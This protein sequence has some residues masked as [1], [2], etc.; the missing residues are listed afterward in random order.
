[1]RRGHFGEWVA[2]PH[3]RYL[4]LRNLAGLSL[5]IV[6]VAVAFADAVVSLGICA[7]AAVYFVLPGRQA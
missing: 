6:A 5:Y 3:Q 2:P 1:V 4:M 7:A